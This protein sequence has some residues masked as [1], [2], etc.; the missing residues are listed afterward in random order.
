MTQNVQFVCILQLEL[1]Y[2]PSWGRR[3]PFQSLAGLL[4]SING[5]QISLQ[6]RQN[7]FIENLI[8]PSNF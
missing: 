1:T 7:T 3:T 8:H 4:V 2:G 6:Y 5:L